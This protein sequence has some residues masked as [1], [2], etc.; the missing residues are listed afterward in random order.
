MKVFAKILVTILKHFSLIANN[1]FTQFLHKKKEIC[2]SNPNPQ[3]SE[4]L[5]PDPLDLHLPNMYC[6]V[7]I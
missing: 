4:R 2:C 7:K 5:N 1:F 6:W 3:L